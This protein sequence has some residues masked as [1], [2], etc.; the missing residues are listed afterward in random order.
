[1]VIEIKCLAFKLKVQSGMQI[2]FCAG[3]FTAHPV[4]G[5]TKFCL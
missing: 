4:N 1:M 5:K 2:F 3:S